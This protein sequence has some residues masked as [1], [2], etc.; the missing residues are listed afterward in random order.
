MEIHVD[1]D[2]RKMG[3]G[4]ELNSFIKLDKCPSLRYNALKQ[5]LHEIL[6][7]SQ[8]D[9][10]TWLPSAAHWSMVKLQHPGTQSQNDII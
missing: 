6:A 4:E 1:S 3:V 10:S 8:V 9:K 5:S 7:A 2:A